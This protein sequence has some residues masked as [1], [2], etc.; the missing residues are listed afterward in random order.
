LSSAA[1]KRSR[2][3]RTTARFASGERF[4]AVP[5]EVLSSP[6]YRA[7]PDW[8]KTVLVALA[9]QF[10]G[11]NNGD[12]ALTARDGLALGVSAEWK[13]YAGLRLLELTGLIVCTRRGRLEN[14]AKIC[15]LY[16]IT[17]RGIVPS[18]KHD[19]QFGLLPLNSWAKWQQPPDWRQQ[20]Q[21]IQ[22]RMRGP[23]RIAT[24]AKK[25]DT[26]LSGESRTPLSGAALPTS[27]PNCRGKESAAAAPRCQETSENSPRGARASEGIQPAFRD[28]GPH[29]RRFSTEAHALDASARVLKLHR[30]QPHLTVADLAKVCRVEIDVAQRALEASQ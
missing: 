8:A 20:V 23:S 11:S 9:G 10:V 19:V 18:T 22:R 6:A 5:L 26:R 16:A 2:R 21:S 12:M 7:L 29:D 14:G 4:S 3:E 28:R 30:A 15:S 25:P 24:P 1:R 17:W 27:A 13:L